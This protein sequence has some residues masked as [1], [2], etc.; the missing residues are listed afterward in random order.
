V[1]QEQFETRMGWNPS[2]RPNCGGG[3]PVEYVH[4]FDA[5]AMANDV[6]TSAGLLACY[7]LSDVECQDGTSV[8]EDYLDCMNETQEGIQAAVVSLNGEASPYECEGYRLPT[9]AEWEYSARG[10]VQ[11]AS[12]P[13]GGNLYPGDEEYCDGGLVLDNGLY[14]DDVAWYCGNDSN[15][16]EAVG[17]LLANGY[18]LYDMSGNV[19][20]W[21]HDWEGDYQGDEVDQ[22][23]PETGSERVFR[24]GCYGGGARSLRNAN[25]NRYEPG[26]RSESLGFRLARTAP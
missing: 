21:C 16:P 17:Q 20:E 26:M 10:G 15:S 19:W 1:T 13:N 22:V 18:G 12:F 6:S 2:Y 9:E 4:W 14:L 3:C 7:V 24:G 8:G 23:G 25:R 5:V 11:G